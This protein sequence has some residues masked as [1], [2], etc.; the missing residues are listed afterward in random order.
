MLCDVLKAGLGPNFYHS[1]KYNT[2]NYVSHKVPSSFFILPPAAKHSAIGYS[3]CGF[4]P[5]YPSGG[6]LPLLCRADV[7]CGMDATVERTG[8]VGDTITPTVEP[9]L[10]L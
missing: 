1:A 2:E 6:Q 4:R 10:K 7:W 3:W 5:I 8:E 9:Q